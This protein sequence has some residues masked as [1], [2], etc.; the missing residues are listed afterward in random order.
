VPLNIWYYATGRIEYFTVKGFS[1]EKHEGEYEDW[2]SKSKL[3]KNGDYVGEKIPGYYIERQFLL[4]DGNYFFITSYDCP[5]EE[6]C[7]LLLVDTQYRQ[8]AKRSL[9]PW[10][11]SSWNFDDHKYLGDNKFLLTFNK[12]YHLEVSLNPKKMFGWRRISWSKV[13]NA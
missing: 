3:L 2:P 9:I 11:Y 4:D 12:T 7:D 6:Q 1:L 10:Y 8:I 13:K 5:F